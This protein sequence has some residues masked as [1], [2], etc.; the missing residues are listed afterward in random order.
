MSGDL[1]AL[2]STW[3][4]VGGRRMHARAAG[5]PITPG[6]RP[7]VCVHGLLVSS[8]SMRPSTRRLAR[9]RRTVAVDLPGFGQS[10]DPPAPLDLPGLADALAAWMAAA[11]LAPA[12][13]LGN[14]FGCQVIAE[15]AARH[16]GCL[17]RAVL[18]GP[19]VDPH[20]RGVV[21]QV[22]RLL[23]DGTREPLP[24]LPVVAR[25]CIDGGLGLLL[26]TAR[27]ALRDRIER[28]L[29]LIRVPTLVVRG[30]RDPLVP[31]RWAEEATRL[32]PDGRLVVIPGAGHAVNYNAPD[33]LA[34]AVHAFLGR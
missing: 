8:R 28:K 21:Q 7:I 16:P 29:P 2:V 22:A 13:L 3:T 5:P 18:I 32:L 30:G 34:R 27:H 23:L 33:D 12:V 4:V 17:E 15:A 14:S 20:H 26:R 19:T 9:S 24:Y 1:P 11:G 31:Q 25:D 6:R 10:D